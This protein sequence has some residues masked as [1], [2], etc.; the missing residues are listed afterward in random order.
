MNCDE[1]RQW[2][3]AY[4]D[5]ELDLSRH[6]E[7]AAHVESCASCKKEAEQ[8]TNFKSFVRSNMPVYQA[9]SELRSKI[10][11]TL[12]K[13]SK[14]RFEW[15]FAYGRQVA[16]AA[17]LIAIGCALSWTWF[18][19]APRKDNQLV[20]DAISNH[21]RSL[22]LAHLVDCASADEHTVRPWFSGKLDYSPP[23]PDLAQAGYALK[24]ARIDMLDGRP[25]A[26][27]VYE[28]GKHVINLFVWPAGD[29]KID[30]DVQTQRGYQFCAWNV[31]GF[32]F[33][34]V[35]D[36]SAADLEAFEDAVREHLNL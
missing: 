19:V 22:M 1:A 23:V 10:R 5:G 35:S 9:P 36:G 21:A 30:I 27:I 32:N 11:A 24:G 17:A 34:C 7:V 28:H 33:F 25:V 2:L 20:F 31:S 13:E 26:A 3:N 15:F 4:V 6:L 29:R 14:T 18:A 12:R 8:L 16:Y